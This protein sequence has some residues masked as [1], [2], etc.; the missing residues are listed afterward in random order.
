MKTK[1][2]EEFICTRKDD[3]LH[4][5]SIY[6][7]HE[8]IYKFKGNASIILDLFFKN[9]QVFTLVE[10]KQLTGLEINEIDWNSFIS[11]LEEKKII[12]N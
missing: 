1:L 10:T 5:V 8:E 3:V 9:K 12:D 11:F 2:N 6:P 7:D 4:V